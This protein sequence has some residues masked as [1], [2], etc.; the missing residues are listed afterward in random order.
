MKTSGNTILITGGATGI[1]FCMA[2]AFLGAGN[3]VLAC[4]RRESKLSEAQGRLPALKTRACDVASE[5]GR[6]S[7]ASWAA[8]LGVNV[9]I[10]NAG[11]QRMV[12]F[13]RGL[14]ALA[15]GDNEIRCNLE[16]PVY[17]TARLVPH[18]LKAKEA[19]ILNVSSA[20]GFVPMAIMPVYCAT[21]AALHSFSVSLRHQLSATV[22]KVFEVIPPTVDTELDRGARARRGQTHRGIAP[23]EVAQAVLQGMGEDRFE[24]PV[25]M[26]TNLVSGSR[27]D[28]DQLF[29]SM[30]AG[31]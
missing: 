3:Q 6:E 17:L 26:A 4:G 1:G 31:H 21:K 29:Q 10:N 7:L 19:A 28:F 11:M 8:S 16:G 13:T 2:Q 15:E 18:L 27:T 20:L 24:I 22:I 9:L 12:D 23:E 5:E 14:A 25:G 30:N